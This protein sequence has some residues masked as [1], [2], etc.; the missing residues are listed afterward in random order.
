MN[1]PYSQLKA[2]LKIGFSTRKPEDMWANRLQ[3]WT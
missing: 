3:W 1:R 2:H